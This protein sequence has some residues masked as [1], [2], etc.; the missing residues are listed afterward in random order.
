MFFGSSKYQLLLYIA[1]NVR[2]V[3]MMDDV[4]CWVIGAEHLAST[5]GVTSDE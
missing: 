5:C 4:A 3:G 1:G 2:S